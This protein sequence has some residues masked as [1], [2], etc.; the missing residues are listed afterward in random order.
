MRIRGSRG[1]TLIEL[2]VVIAIIAVLIA[3]L[4][5]A[6]QSA[7]EAARR[8]QCVNNLKQISLAAHNYHD[9]NGAFPM[10]NYS[11][12]YNP[13]TNIFPSRAVWT[14]K[15]AAGCCPWGSYSWSALVLGFIEG[16][17]IFNAINFTLPAYA[18]S[19][20]ET[21]GPWGGSSGNR[22]SEIQT[23]YPGIANSTIATMAP[24][25]FSCPSVP[26]VILSVGVSPGPR[27]AWKDYGM[28][29][30]SGFIGCCPERLQGDGSPNPGDGMGT[31]NQSINLRD[32]TDGTSNTFH[33]ME[34]SRNAEHS[35]IAKNTGSNQFIWVH[36]PSQGQIVA[37]ELGSSSPP[38]PPNSNFP[39]S[40]GAVGGHP[41]GINVSFADG[42][43]AFIKNSINFQVYRGLFSRNRGEV[44]SADAV[45]RPSR[46]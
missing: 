31:V 4:L 26:D 23:G 37:G 15:N 35:W 32:V 20:P 14:E 30:G 16:T 10:A 1:F 19:L 9:V 44:I 41:G 18:T 46:P 5:P 36:H 21:A 27:G 34:L 13:G 45:S 28:N 29:V 17:N 43:V 33:F 6:V 25:S 42:H 24:N 2:L 22:F 11:A 3:L 39:N 7:R 12:L 38:F 8:A 40:R